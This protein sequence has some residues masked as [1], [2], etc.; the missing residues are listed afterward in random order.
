MGPEALHHAYCVLKPL[1]YLLL[2]HA[3][4]SNGF[5]PDMPLAGAAPLPEWAPKGITYRQLAAHDA[6]LSEPLAIAW[7]ITPPDE[8]EKLLVAVDRT[9]GPAFSEVSGGLLAECIIEHLTGRTANSYCMEELLE[10]LGLAEDIIVDPEL[11]ASSA[12]RIRSPLI[13]LP[14]E[15]L[16]MLSELLPDHIAEIRLALGAY[17]TMSATARLYAAIGDVAAGHTRPGL[18][19]PAL[20]R[21][22]LDDDRPLR[23][24]PVLER[25]TKWCAG[26]MT[27]LGEQG[28]SHAAGPH[29]FGHTAGLANSIA[30]HDPSRGASLALYLNGVGVEDDD[31]IIPRRRIIDTILHAIPRI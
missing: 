8:R 5:D 9:Q 19:S 10:P 18:P 27:E 12:R 15:P 2:A 11:A 3:L 13:G 31:H 7:K 16:P 28:L 22:L 14:L 1:P 23:Y 24:D 30:L 4:E 29:S 6:A 26:L 20:L 17:A 25:P 21:N